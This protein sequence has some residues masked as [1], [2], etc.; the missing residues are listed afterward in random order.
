MD[1]L[2]EDLQDYGVKGHFNVTLVDSRKVANGGDYF[3]Y[4]VNKGRL[5]IVFEVDLFEENPNFTDGG[6]YVYC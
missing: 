6:E 5:N 3:M 4:H 2:L 1:E